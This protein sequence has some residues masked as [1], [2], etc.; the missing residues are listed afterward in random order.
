V[1]GGV[2]TPLPPLAG[3]GG[4][5]LVTGATAGSGAVVCEVV[6]EGDVVVGVVE[7]LTVSCCVPVTP[8]AFA[9]IVAVPGVAGAV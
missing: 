1:F 4:G 3:G 2:K 8:P 6:V 7:Q 9:V 5:G